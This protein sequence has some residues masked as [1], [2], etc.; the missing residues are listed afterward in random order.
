[1]AGWPGWAP[2]APCAVVP[3]WLGPA[4]GVAA[5]CA[6]AGCPAV[7]ACPACVAAAASAVGVSAAPVGERRA[8]RRLCLGGCGRLLRPRRG[9]GPRRRRVPHD[10]RR[11]TRRRLYARG[12]GGG[13]RRCVRLC[14]RACGCDWRAGL[15]RHVRRRART[16]HTCC[17]ARRSRARG[18]RP[19][20]GAG[21]RRARY[22]RSRASPGGAWRTRAAGSR[23]RHAC[24][25]LHADDQG[26]QIVNRGEIVA[27][28]NRH[29]LPGG[30][31]DAAR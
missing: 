25:H 27:H 20:R 22:D 11:L 3:P 16:C 30:H 31:N 28:H 7:P 15:R 13:R 6:V 19:R 8:L 10:D 2:G 18:A 23:A 1:M 26:T 12:R 4:P 5:V 9:R 21:T 14:A 17:G 29:T 24:R